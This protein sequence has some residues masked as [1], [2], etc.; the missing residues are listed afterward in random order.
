MT[1]TANQQTAHEA[2]AVRVAIFIELAFAAG[3]SRLSTLLN[4]IDWGGYTW[5]GIGTVASIGD[6]DE[7][8]SIT[9]KPLTFTLNVADASIL[10]LAAGPVEAYRGRAAKLYVCPLTEGFTLIDTP[11]LAWSGY[12]DALFL[13]VDGEAG[14]VTMKCET[15]AFSLKRLPQLRMNAAQHKKDNPADTGFDYLTDLIANPQLW[16]S[17][18]FQAV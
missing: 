13:A 6:I 2:A 18:K 14:S 10:A 4:D 12:M 11:E 1:L 8:A 9:A 3:T 7:S 5:K 17:K 16:L 15:A